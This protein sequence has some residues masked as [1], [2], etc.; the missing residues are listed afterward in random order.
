MQ[1]LARNVSVL[2]CVL[3]LVS[4]GLFGQA[5]SGTV[6]GTITDN[7]GAVVPGAT[8][9]MT[10]VN[11]AQTRS[12]VTG[13]AGEYAVP[14]LRPDTYSITVERE[15]FQKYSRKVVV[16]VGSRIDLSAQLSVSGASTTVEVTSSGETAAV[17]T[18]TQTLSQ[19]ITAQDITNLPTLTRNPYDLVATSGNVSEDQQSG[20]GAGVAVNGQRSSDTN[21]LLDGG[22]NVDLFNASVGQSVPLDSVQEFRVATSNYTAEYGRAG[23]GVVNVTTKSGSNQFHGSLYEFN[24][25]SALSSNPY[26]N[27]ANDIPKAGLHAQ[28]VWLR[29]RRTNRQEQTVLLQQH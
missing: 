29:P 28:S 26:Q 23:G 2:L 13:S 18:E 6:S 7:T 14:S 8:V 4:V 20:R 3:L 10:S 22:E 19:V 16:D 21:I 1:H 11:T 25:V 9:T 17:N 15:G 12:A 24:R 5:E 27:D